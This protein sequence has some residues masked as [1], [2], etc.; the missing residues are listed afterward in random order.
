MK[1]PFSFLACRE[2]CEEQL[3][4]WRWS[5]STKSFA[6][7]ITSLNF[8]FQRSSVNFVCS[9]P[10]QS[11]QAKQILSCGVAEQ[12]LQ[13]RLG[14]NS[15]TWATLYILFCRVVLAKGLAQNNLKLYVLNKNKGVKRSKIIRKKL[16][17]TVEMWIVEKYI[18]FT[19]KLYLAFAYIL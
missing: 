5:N 16:K 11:E 9:G 2:C 17:L 10:E 18:I 6:R 13:E 8:Y 3:C 14:T 15:L 19:K 12:K 4:R 7:G 1:W